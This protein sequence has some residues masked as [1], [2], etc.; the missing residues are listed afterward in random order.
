M[1]GSRGWVLVLGDTHFRY[2]PEIRSLYH[3]LM[4]GYLSSFSARQHIKPLGTANHLGSKGELL[5]RSREQRLRPLEIELV[6][7]Q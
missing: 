7:L 3:L 5:T 1:L 6:P 2:W 4:N